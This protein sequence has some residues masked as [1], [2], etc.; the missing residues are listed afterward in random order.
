LLTPPKKEI[1]L[2]PGLSDSL[3]VSSKYYEGILMKFCG[4]VGD[5]PCRNW[6][7]F[8]GDLVPG[9]RI[10]IHGYITQTF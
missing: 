3:F 7:D 1:L 2:Q 6:L 8:G 10:Q 4:G 5:S 9:S